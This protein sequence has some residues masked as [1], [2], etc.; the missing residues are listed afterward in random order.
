MTTAGTGWWR[1]TAAFSPSAMPSTRARCPPRA[2]RRPTLW[3]S[4]ATPPPTATTSSAPTER[5]GT[6]T[7][8]SS[9]TCRLRLP[10]QQ[11]RGRRADARRQG[12]VPGGRG[13]Q[14]VQPAGGRRLPGRRVSLHAQRP[15]RG[16]GG[17]SGHGR[18]LAGGRDGGVFSYGAPFFGST[19]NLRLNQPVI[20]M[21]ADR[22]RRRLLVHRSRR[23]RLLL[24]RRPVLGLDRQHRAEPA[25]G[26]HVRLLSRSAVAA[27]QSRADVGQVFPHRRG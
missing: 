26:R 2:S 4:S 13:R 23:R 1:P 3:G 25:C 8:P 7:L 17:R 14:G 24:R 21:S 9:A 20:A 19:G 18:V 10:R 16:H 15:H 12:P 6:S 11:H 27:Q 5:Y 22:R